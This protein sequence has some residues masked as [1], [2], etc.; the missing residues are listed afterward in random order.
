M[1]WSCAAATSTWS[2][3]WT[4]PTTTSS[5]SQARFSAA[6]GIITGM[7]SAASC[8]LIGGYTAVSEPRTSWP[9]SARRPATA[10]I[11]VP[12]IPMRWTFTPA[13]E[14]TH[15]TS[16]GKRPARIGYSRTWK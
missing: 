9:A 10:P 11:P 12:P 2:L 8:S 1:P 13:R 3:P 16:S 14:G 5:G 6:Y 15:E 7:P 4:L